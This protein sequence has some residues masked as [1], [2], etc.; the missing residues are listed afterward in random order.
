MRRNAFVLRRW[1]AGALVLIGVLVLALLTWTLLTLT[2]RLTWTAD[3]NA[4]VIGSLGDWAAGVFTGLAVALAVLQFRSARRIE[5]ETERR[6]Q[7]LTVGAWAEWGA[8]ADADPSTGIELG[9]ALPDLPPGATSPE[10]RRAAVLNGS[11]GVIYDWSVTIVPSN[12]WPYYVRFSAR[13][14]VL[15]PNVPVRVAL[16]GPTEGFVVRAVGSEPQRAPAGAPRF[17]VLNFTDAWGE[18][19]IRT[20]G[21]LQPISR[22]SAFLPKMVHLRNPA[23]SWAGYIDQATWEAC[24]AAIGAP[25]ELPEQLLALAPAGGPPVLTHRDVEQLHTM[26]VGARP[27]VRRA[28]DF[29]H[30]SRGIRRRVPTLASYLRVRRF[31][32]DVVQ[33]GRGGVLLVEGD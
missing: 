5:L 1:P 22:E 12:G 2:D 25:P 17:V 16:G 8:A 13:T 6:A 23:M 20:N 29:R 24:R 18:P 31:L 14:G 21:D 10:T 19:W 3:A 27:R 11:A 30:Q 26:L 28:H 33:A 32:H 4:Q 9:R 15:R 7:A